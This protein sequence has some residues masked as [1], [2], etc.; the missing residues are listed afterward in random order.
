MVRRV[1]GSVPT[2]SLEDGLERMAG[3]ARARGPQDAPG[4]GAI[5]VTR[6]LPS[7]WTGG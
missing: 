1:F 5:G 3:R 7:S 6:N 4:F 2:T